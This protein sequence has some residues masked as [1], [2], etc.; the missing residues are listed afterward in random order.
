MYF[1]YWSQK[2]WLSGTVATSL[3]A[4]ACKRDIK[5]AWRGCGTLSLARWATK[6]AKHIVAKLEQ[7]AKDT[8]KRVPPNISNIYHPVV[9]LPG[10]GG[11]SYIKKM[12]GKQGG[13]N[14]LL[15]H[16]FVWHKGSTNPP[17]DTLRTYIFFFYVGSCPLFVWE[18]RGYLASTN[19]LLSW[20]IIELYE[21]HG[22]TF[23]TINLIRFQCWMLMSDMQ[24]VVYPPPTNS[25]LLVV[26]WFRD[27]HGDTSLFPGMSEL[28][29]YYW[30]FLETVAFSGGLHRRSQEFWDLPSMTRAH[31]IF[32]RKIQGQKLMYDKGALVQ[33]NIFIVCCGGVKI[34]YALTAPPYHSKKRPPLWKLY[35][36]IPQ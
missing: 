8:L 34:M 13:D 17:S 22:V 23:P 28:F 31:C 1:A 3:L 7:T 12:Y 6:H 21:A 4:G 32:P 30:R 36:K 10:G 11:E 26:Q 35:A 2:A 29:Q 9:T 19:S 15:K 20:I 33:R 14:P 18:S 5:G 16:F 27:I 25:R 24:G